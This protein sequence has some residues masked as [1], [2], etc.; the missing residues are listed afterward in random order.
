MRSRH[1]LCLETGSRRLVPE[2]IWLADS[3][4][5]NCSRSSSTSP[6][7]YRLAPDCRGHGSS[8]SRA[9][10]GRMLSATFADATKRDTCLFH[11][12]P[13]RA[14]YVSQGGARPDFLRFG[15][16]STTRNARPLGAEI[17]PM[18]STRAS[19]SA[20]MRRLSKRSTG[21]AGCDRRPR[22][23]ARASGRPGAGKSSVSARGLWPRLAR[24][25]VN[26]LP[27]SVIRPERPRL[28]WTGLLGALK[29]AATF[30]RAGSVRHR[31][32]ALR[33]SPVARRSCG[34]LTRTL[35]GRPTRARR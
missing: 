19:F 15:L 27:L 24:D 2:G 4:T 26:F 7:H 11:R 35:A 29:S 30:G 17:A 9:G 23:Y 33:R 31:R 22:L 32:V 1:F 21:C 18:L 16:Q 14:P 10:G 28:R 5:R 8:Q 25:D 6:R 3:S 12:R 13:T 34:R 20:A